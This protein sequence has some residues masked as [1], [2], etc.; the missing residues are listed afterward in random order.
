MT[1]LENKEKLI[2]AVDNY[3]VYSTQGRAI[4]KTLIAA[5]KEDYT[6]Q[7]SVS[8]LS[9]LSK[10]S[11][12]G[13]YNSMGYLEENNLVTRSK[14]KG[15]RLSTFILNKDE[16]DKIVDYYDNLVRTKSFLKRI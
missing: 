7:L 2:E 15:K 9:D 5:A 10:V 4:L 12:Q 11:R 1:N 3:D 14:I 8:S 13:I 16:L 6:V